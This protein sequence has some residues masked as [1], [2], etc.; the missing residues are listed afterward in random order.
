VS[1]NAKKYFDLT[2]FLGDRVPNLRSGKN[3]KAWRPGNKGGVL[4]ALWNIGRQKYTIML[5]PHSEKQTIHFQVTFFT[6]FFVGIIL[7]ALLT[8]FLW[9]SLDFSDKEVLLASRSRDL[10]KT[11]ASLD[12]VRDE[13]GQLV[14]SADVFKESVNN[15][16]GILEF[17]ENAN[18]PT[19]QGGDLSS[20]LSIKQSGQGTLTEITDLK[21]LRVTLENSTSALENI[22]SILVGQK[23]LLSD[24]PTR[25]PLKGVNGWTTQVFGPSIHPIRKHWYL[26][27]GLDLAFLY[28]TPIVSTANG[29]VVK[30][31]YDPQG[32]GLYI[33]IQHNYGFKTRYAHLQRQLVELGQPVLRG[34][35]I[36]T[37]GNSGQSTGAHLHYE[38]MI[39]T[40]LVDPIK[41]LNMAKT[42][43]PTQQVLSKLQRYQ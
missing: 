15:A 27:R 17:D 5:V 18:N 43:S 42:N 12:S 34:D 26:H 1:Y 9:I 38:V 13:V 16:I 39:G 11:E 22:S 29:K 36:G 4:G 40:Q 30:I 8:G 19:T 21:A 7:L 2:Y 41:F 28:G 33:D 35:V 14:V 32:F 10:S 31:D 23:D 3:K 25:W 6:V 37:M 24:I 20:L